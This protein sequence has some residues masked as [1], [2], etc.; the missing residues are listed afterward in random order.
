MTSPLRR[1]A[2]ALAALAWLAVFSLLYTLGDEVGAWPKLPPGAFVNL[3]LYAGLIAGLLLL[4]VLF[5]PDP[6]HR[7]CD[8]GSS[9]RHLG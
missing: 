6:P 5:L 3:D 2:P 8:T 7:T 9:G 1:A 4:A